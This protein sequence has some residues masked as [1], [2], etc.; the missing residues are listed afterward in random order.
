[1]KP[2][3][4]AASPHQLSDRCKRVAWSNSLEA[5]RADAVIIIYGNAT[6]I[7]IKVGPLEH[8]DFGGSEPMAVRHGEDGAVAPVLDDRVECSTSGV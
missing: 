5:I 2:P 4:C 8:A 3:Q 7:Q 6:L 1:M